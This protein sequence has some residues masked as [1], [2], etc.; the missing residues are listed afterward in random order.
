MFYLFYDLNE[1]LFRYLFH[2][3]RLYLFDH[4]R[5]Q[6]LGLRREGLIR[7]LYWLLLIQFSMPTFLLA[8]TILSSKRLL[9]LLR[10][11]LLIWLLR[12]GIK[13]NFRSRF[14]V[15]LRLFHDFLHDLNRHFFD[16]FLHDLN[17]HFFDHLYYSDHLIR[18]L[19]VS[20]YLYWRNY[21]FDDFQCNVLWDLYFY[22]F[23]YLFDYFHW[24]FHPPF[25]VN[26]NLNF[27]HFFDFDGHFDPSLNVNWNLNFLH[28]FDFN[29]PDNLY[30]Y[31]YFFC[32]FDENRQLH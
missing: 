28:F 13:I 24:N 14:L 18:Y 27:L 26:R 22:L 15:A 31:C 1:G 23:Y 30:W 10:N 4:L 6:E 5:S 9:L 17:R 29:L 20:Q 16:D 32:D 8:L 19:D 7:Y 25:N 12:L 11:N 21:F 2:H 3:F